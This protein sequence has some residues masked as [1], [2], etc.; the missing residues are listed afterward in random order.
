MPK[1]SYLRS[2]YPDCVVAAAVLHDVLED[3]DAERSELE[4]RFG[5]EVAELV[6]LVS[7]DPSI[8]DEEQ[9]EDDVRERV[10]RAGG[11]ALVVYAADKVATIRELR[12]LMTGGLATP[13][14]ARPDGVSEGDERARASDMANPEL[15]HSDRHGRAR[16]WTSRKPEA[17]GSPPRT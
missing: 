12:T 4:A 8:D 2:H 3:T 11:Y 9:R 15:L 17:R 7:D 1:V 14:D 13:D 10:R 5:P 6:A 16:C